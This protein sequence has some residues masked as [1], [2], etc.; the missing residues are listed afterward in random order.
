MIEPTLILA[1]LILLAVWAAL[2]FSKHERFGNIVFMIRSGYGVKLIDSIAEANPR[3]WQFLAD[4]SVLLS[5][6]GVGGYYLSSHNESRENLY[7][8]VMLAGAVSFL[9]GAYVGKIGA[10]LSFL[11][12]G[13]L[14]SLLMRRL[15][16]SAADFA[17]SAL[18]F[19][20]ASSLILSSTAASATLNAA[21]SAICGV[22]GLPAVMIYVLASHGISI[23]A[24]Q[25]N[26]PGVSPMLP[27]TQGGN[28]GVTFPGY[29]LFIPWWYVLVALIVTLVVH[30][31][32][33]GVLIRVAKVKLKS[34]G[35]LSVFS[36]PIGAFAEPDEQELNAKTSVERMRV[37]TVG[38]FANLL[39]G[40]AAAVL[41]VAL[42]N[43]S[44]HYVIADG[45]RVVGFI[46]GYPAKDV[47]PE[48]A[49]IYSVDG[50]PTANLT[51]LRDIT[52][53]LPPG[54]DIALNTSKGSFTLRLASN[55]EA[56]GKGYIGAYLTENL[57]LEGAIGGVVSVGI[58]GFL[59]EM[60]EWIAF[61][62]INIALV[63]ILPLIPFDGGR[64]FKEVVE[65]LQMSE[66]NVKR[67]LYAMIS[68][69]A[70]LFLVNLLPLLGMFIDF[71]F[72]LV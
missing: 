48:G 43:F 64:M 30:E 34:T 55:P 50:K 22:F 13:V 41:I 36:L 62:N 57:R 20:L 1:G 7:R 72:K 11:A 21:T 6:G 69:M 16:S 12:L 10:G 40:F 45:V 47:L 54:T 14:I 18:I 2:I 39:T 67:V 33:H 3:L 59:L 24:A 28:V 63:N 70:V 49:I 19:F 46:D 5:F 29:D 8:S 65:T 68:F 4:F 31:G 66:V 58:L 27:A 15:R 38:S 42:I 61:F 52:S 37:F 53:T 32:A 17:L 25:T 44:S 23:L 60:L 51:A 71:L 26:V 35:I 9:A 56:P